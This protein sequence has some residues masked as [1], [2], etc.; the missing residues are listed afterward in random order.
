MSKN[1]L[2]VGRS[3]TNINNTLLFCNPKG[4][5]AK[6]KN[7]I[8]II[9]SEVR[10]MT[11]KLIGDIE[12]AE[13]V[14]DKEGRQYHIGLAKGEL[15]ENIV[16]VGDP[17][18][19]NLVKKVFSEIYI[20][21]QVREFHTITGQIGKTDVS[22]MSTGIGPSN[23]EICMVEIIQVCESP[24]VIRAGS[25]GALHHK[26]NVGDLV[27][28][29]G[30]VRFEDTSTYFIPEGYPAVADWEVILAL[31]EAAM[32]NNHKYHIGLSASG[33][34]F[35]GAQGRVIP[36]LPIRNPNTIDYLTQLN[37]LNFEMEASTLFNLAQIFGLR[38]GMVCAVFTNRLRDEF[39]SNE[40]KANA[41]INCVTTALDALRIL[42]QMDSIKARQKSK[43][44]SPSFKLSNQV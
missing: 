1:S 8:S 36:G 14:S 9:N 7:S 10:V 38:A 25:C 43:F 15:A 32:R 37:V 39:I 27:I 24:T 13:I 35:Y 40:L 26:V 6:T 34:G 44:W 22:I 11:K 20:E 3:F 33:S 30:S 16:L 18:R 12:G 42:E 21:T 19:P 17:E 41:E 2:L 5:V 31:N 29:T 28:S 23:I 4:F